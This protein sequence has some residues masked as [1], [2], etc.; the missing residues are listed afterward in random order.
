MNLRRALVNPPGDGIARVPEAPTGLGLLPA[1]GLAFRLPAGM[2]AVSYSRV[3][4]EPTAA[5]RTRS[6][7]GLWHGDASWSP[8]GG[9]DDPRLRSECLGHFWKAGVGKFSRAPKQLCRAALLG[10]WVLRV[11]DRAR[12]SADPHLIRRQEQEDQ[13]LD[14]LKLDC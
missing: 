11:H 13:R 4:P 9:T 5:D 3:W 8:C 7:P 2:L 14:Q 12:R 10:T 1:R 6:L